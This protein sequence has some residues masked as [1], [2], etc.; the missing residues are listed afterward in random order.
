MSNMAESQNEHR[1]EQTR[2][3]DLLIKTYSKQLFN[4]GCRFCDDEEIVKDCI[5]QLYLDLWNRDFDVNQPDKIKFYL[6]KAIKNR[7]LRE[8]AKWNKSESLNDE[9]EFILE[10]GIDT[11]LI[12]DIQ[13]REISARLEK[14]LNSL[15]PRQREI[16]YLKF[17]E[18]LDTTQIASIMD[19]NRQS[20]HNLLQKAYQSIKAD[21]H[22]YLLFLLLIS[23][24]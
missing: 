19:L 22:V 7:V 9:Y 24:P 13:D 14:I 3:Y 15:P 21:W 12:L 17:Y 18:N 1:V 6:F 4:F 5:Q 16:I 2:A 8:K 10:F 23:K 20:V 11:K